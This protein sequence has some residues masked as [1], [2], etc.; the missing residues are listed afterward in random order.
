[1]SD[2][3]EGSEESLSDCTRYVL[4]GQNIPTVSGQSIPTVSGQHRNVR[5]GKG[6][7][8]QSNSAHRNN[9][10]KMKRQPP[11]REQIAALQQQ[12]HRL[13]DQLATSQF[14]KGESQAP[15]VLSVPSTI[16]ISNRG[17][18]HSRL[19]SVNPERILVHNSV[20]HAPLI[21]LSDLPAVSAQ[22]RLKLARWSEHI[23][24]SDLLPINR[25]NLTEQLASGSRANDARKEHISSYAGWVQAFHVF[26]LHRSYYFPKMSASFLKYANVIATIAEPNSGYDEHQW[27]AYDAQFRLLATQ[28]PNNS[29]IWEDLHFQTAQSC[30]R[31]KRNRSSGLSVTRKCYAC[32]E[33]GHIA[34]ACPQNSQKNGGRQLFHGRPAGRG[35]DYS[36]QTCYSFNDGN[37]PNPC[38]FGRSHKCVICNSESHGRFNHP[39]STSSNGTGK[40]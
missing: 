27:L 16:A 21:K 6:H 22:M 28:Q 37:C 4:R 17:L 35:G 40:P 8:R 38:A 7:G 24:L 13:E 29:Q 10:Q 25:A 9:T 23:D 31:L 3:E 11:Q 39:P 26:A 19:G 33:P 34:P 12:V 2:F 1:M 36:F 18:V 32:G 15:S 30:Q 14:Q 20:D 5:K